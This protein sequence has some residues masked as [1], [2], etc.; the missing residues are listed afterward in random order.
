[1]SVRY[2]IAFAYGGQN[3][4]THV[5][6]ND[7]NIKTEICIFIYMVKMKLLICLLTHWNMKL[8]G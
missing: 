1:V 2:G 3:P 8:H 4:Q 5:H 6:E 7:V